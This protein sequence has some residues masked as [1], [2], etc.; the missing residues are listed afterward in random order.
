MKVL[1]IEDDINKMQA[2]TNFLWEHSAIK[3]TCKMSYHSGM[4]AILKERFDIL[5]LD[6]SM[7][8]YDITT[9]DAGGGR[10][11]ALAGRDILF[12]LRRRQIGM[13]VIVITQYENFG[14]FSLDEL[15]H[16]LQEEFPQQYIGYV[17]YNTTQEG[18]KEKLSALLEI[19]L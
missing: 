15:D 6:M 5:L 8:V 16:E 19:K 1:I 7:P 2:I 3:C 9:Q 13:Q 12:Q 11:L 14:G 4:Q 17:Y 10:P 18:W